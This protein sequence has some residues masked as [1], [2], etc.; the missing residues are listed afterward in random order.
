MHP[1]DLDDPTGE[2]LLLSND[3]DIGVTWPQR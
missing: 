3:P 2:I 1:T